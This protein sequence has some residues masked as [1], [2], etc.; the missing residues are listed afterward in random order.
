MIRSLGQESTFADFHGV[1]TPTMANF[2]LQ[3]DILNA[4]LGRD[5]Q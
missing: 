5:T 2:K 3:H 4:F 1:N